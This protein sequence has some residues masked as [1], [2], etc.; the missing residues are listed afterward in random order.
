MPLVQVVV[1]ILMSGD[2][3]SISAK[4]MALTTM[5]F[6]VGNTDGT[7][8]VAIA[9]RA[10]DIIRRNTCTV[11]SILIGIAGTA[12]NKKSGQSCIGGNRVL[13]T[14]HAHGC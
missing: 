6:F 7:M 2:A 9:R 3:V 13:R 10:V 5:G 12:A 1:W 11:E 8:L 14:I 4:H